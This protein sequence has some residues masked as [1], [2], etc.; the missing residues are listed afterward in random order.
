MIQEAGSIS[1]VGFALS[2]SPHILW[3]YLV[4]VRKGMSISIWQL[5]YFEY[6]KNSETLHPNPFAGP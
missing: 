2:K 1:R 3:G 5:Q 6:E 4:T